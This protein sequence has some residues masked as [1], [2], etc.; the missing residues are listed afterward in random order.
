MNPTGIRE[1]WQAAAQSG[2][3]VAIQQAAARTGV[4]F[5][6]LLG[7][8]RIESGFDPNA[9]ARTSSATGLFQFIEQTWLATVQ[10]HGDKHGLGWAAG[11]IKQGANG[12]Y[13]VAD[14]AMRKAILDMRKDPQAASAMAAEFAADNQNYLENSLGRPM[15]SVDL[16]LAHFLGAGGAQKFLSAHDANPNAPAASILPA[17][18]RANRSIFYGKNGA[19]RSFAEIRERFAAKLG[20]SSMPLPSPA[21]R[22][23]PQVQMALQETAPK[24]AGPSPQYARLAYLMLAQL[25]G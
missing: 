23:Y 14:P 3:G 6:Y 11:A 24:V 17:A 19:A 9:R 21:A 7:Q 4:D 1:S 13:H 12:R 2:V 18:A 8:A 15:E 16:Y 22:D 5:S 10:Q 25:G 20:G